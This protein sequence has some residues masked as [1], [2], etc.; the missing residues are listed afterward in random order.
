M[1]SARNASLP[2]KDSAG[3]R[4]WNSFDVCSGMG[5]GCSC[6]LGMA[7]GRHSRRP[8]GPVSSFCQALLTCR[9]MSICVS[10]SLADC[11]LQPP[12]SLLADMHKIRIALVPTL[13]RRSY[14]SS[15]RAGPARGR[16]DST[17]LH[18][19]SMSFLRMAAAARRKIARQC[20]KKRDDQADRARALNGRL[21][22]GQFCLT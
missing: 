8:C 1:R 22:I 3:L 7:F 18:R 10:S 19:F 6:L 2:F 9:I 4:K 15:F 21:P 13:R 12:S 17:L 16:R 5:G 20:V 11:F 14:R